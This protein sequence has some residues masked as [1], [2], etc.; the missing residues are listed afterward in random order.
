LRER[1]RERERE[2]YG[3]RDIMDLSKISPLVTSHQTNK[4]NYSHKWINRVTKTKNQIFFKISTFP[5]HASWIFEKS[6]L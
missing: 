5:T 3:F 2:R 4:E 1:E 6:N